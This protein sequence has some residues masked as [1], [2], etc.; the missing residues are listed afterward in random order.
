MLFNI[1]FS[2]GL[3]GSTIPCDKTPIGDAVMGFLRNA[4]DRSGGRKRRLEK[5]AALQQRQEKEETQS[6]DRK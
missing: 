6:N 2:D 3:R 5:K 4:C 1:V